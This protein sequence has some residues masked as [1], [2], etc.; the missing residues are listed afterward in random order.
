VP[1]CPDWDLR[2]LVTHLGRVQRSWASVIRLGEDVEPQGPDE[3]LRPGD[4]LVGWL[5]ARTAEAIARHQDVALA[6]AL[7]DWLK[8]D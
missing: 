2:E 3:S 6:S 7:V 4:D 8:V 5:R 1:C